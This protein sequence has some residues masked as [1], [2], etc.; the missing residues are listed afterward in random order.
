MDPQ[1]TGF[2]SNRRIILVGVRANLLEGLDPLFKLEEQARSQFVGVRLSNIYRAVKSS[3]TE[4]WL[5]ELW[6]VLRFD[7]DRSMDELLA[8]A[9]GCR[10]E[11]L[12]LKILTYGSR[13]ELNPRHPFPHPDLR[14]ERI[15]VQCAAEVEPS[16]IHPILGQTLLQLVN[17]DRRSIM[18]D[19]FA[20]GLNLH[21]SG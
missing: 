8:W 15:F 14:R 11:N 18:A 3:G 2:E 6:A 5:A 9:E 19:F 4:R 21:S 20:Q 1:I 10:N 13:V 17:S 12:V 16:F 7:S